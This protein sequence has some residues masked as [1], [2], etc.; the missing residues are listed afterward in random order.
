MKASYFGCMGYSERHK[1]P[2]GWPVPPAYHDPEVSM[3]SYREGM[4]ECELAE[5]LGFDWLSLSEHHYSGN[6]TTPNPAV[7]AAAVAERCKRA[8]IALLGQLLP[9]NNPV[10]AAEEIGMLETSPAV[11]W[12][13]PSCGAPSAR[14]RSTT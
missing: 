13:W 3:Q 1:F 9:L 11:G 14:T 10:R 2:P 5:E 6:R 12:W 7:M 4:E 8:K